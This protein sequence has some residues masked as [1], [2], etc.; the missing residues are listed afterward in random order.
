M[1]T[2]FKLSR[3]TV[4]GLPIHPERVI[5]FGTGNFMRAFVDWQLQQM[6]DRGLFAGSA[7]GVQ[8]VSEQPDPEF[9]AQDYL[10]TVLLRGIQGGETVDTGEIV[11]SVSRVISAYTDYEQFLALAEDERLEFITSNTTEAGIVYR[12]EDRLED[13]PPAGFPAKLTVL[14]HRRYRLGRKGFTVIPCELIDR[15]GE[16]LLEIVKLHAADWEL[17][18]GF[19]R[20]L[21]E[22]N[23]FCCSLVDRIVPGY[24]REQAEELEQNLG[25]KDEFMVAAEPFLL[26]VIEGP[27]RLRQ[28]LPLAE[29]GLNVVVTSD[30]TPYRERKVHLLN[31]PHTAMVPLGLLAGLETV[32]EVMHDADLSAFVLELVE[33]ELI[34]MLDLPEPELRAYSEAVLERF[35]NPFIRHELRSISLNS[36]SKFK[37]RLLPLLRRYAAE[38]GELP[39]LITL[40]FAALLHSYRG[41]KVRRQ[42]EA[43]TLELFDRAAGDPS[44]FTATVLRQQEWWGSDLN[45]LPG[46]ADSL[47]ARMD[48][49]GRSGVR[50]ALRRILRGE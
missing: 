11:S 1:K 18:E 4:S 19:L 36:I 20:W 12:P 40:A 27:D 24:P 2:S 28:T 6:N 47:N 5:Q 8:A 43:Q 22:E 42:D 16:K 26:W 14:L 29:A 3:K 33:R 15:N 50:S 13:A 37:A 44:T 21:D 48:E 39:P 10:Y 30:M 25:Y 31:G 38:R 32:E 9:A 41:G 7:V 34:P 46:L 45:E 35:R 23:T 17:G 49:I